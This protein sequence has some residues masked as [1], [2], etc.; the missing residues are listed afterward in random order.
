[1]S[2]SRLLYI[3]NLT[4][5]GFAPFSRGH[6]AHQENAHRALHLRVGFNMPLFHG[7]EPLAV[8]DEAPSG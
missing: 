1:V 4:I 5:T 8:G 3:I 2:R 6:A 7:G